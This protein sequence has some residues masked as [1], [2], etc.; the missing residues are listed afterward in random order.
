M[1]GRRKVRDETSLGKRRV[2]GR[3]L[4]M[5]QGTIVEGFPSHMGRW[6]QLTGEP[7]TSC[8]ALEPTLNMYQYYSDK[9]TLI[10]MVIKALCHS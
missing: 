8:P 10:M 4:P 5:G 7:K 3:N 1:G 2:Q 9:P 6:H